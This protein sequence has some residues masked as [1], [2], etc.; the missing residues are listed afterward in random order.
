MKYQTTL[1][2]LLFALNALAQTDSTGKITYS[3]YG[4][5]YYGFDFSKPENHQKSAFLYNHKRHNELN[6]NLLLVKANY[7]ERATR[8]NLGVMAGNYAQYNLSA[9]P[10]W[11]QHIYEANIGVKLSKKS[12]IWLD[13]GIMPSH[14]GFES[15]ISADC[16]TL[17]R[18]LLAENSPYFESGAKVT[19]TNPQENLSISGL[20]LNGW[21]R[22]TRLD[23][24]Q[25]PSFGF[26]VNYKPSN[27]LVLNYSNFI[28]SDSPDRQKVLRTYH[29]LF[30]QYDDQRKW[31]II[32]GFDIGTQKLSVNTDI[33]YSPV[34][35]VRYNATDRVRFAVRGEYYSDKNRV[36]VATNSISGFKTSGVSGNFDY[37]LSD[38]AAWRFEAKW[39]GSN[40]AL[41][42]D[43]KKTNISLVANLTFRI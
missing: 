15:A 42:D 32:T 30:L 19:Y 3:A 24:V 23:G 16:W 39:Y 11:A 31:G 1:L 26:Q 18:S 10:N 4:E 6:A 22:I 41:F 38:R 34:A 35:I 13:A 8:V 20:L 14:I 7:S 37:K 27:T 2:C 40:S 28:G 21:Q 9:E 12:N 5:L 17:T 33:W 25:K 43:G 36:I 29:N